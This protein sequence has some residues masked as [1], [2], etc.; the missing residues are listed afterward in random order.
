M[1]TYDADGNIAYDD[2]Y[3]PEPAPS[4]LAPIPV[5]DRGEIAAAQAVTPQL[6]TAACARSP[7]RRPTRATGS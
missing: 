1:P 7:S 2:E 4:A 5:R 3:A 6:A